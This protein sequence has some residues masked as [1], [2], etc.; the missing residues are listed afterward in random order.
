MKYFLILFL[1]IWLTAQPNDS[2]LF[3]VVITHTVVTNECPD[4]LIIKFK[5]YNRSEKAV[6]TTTLA[7]WIKE[8]NSYQLR[9]FHRCRT[10][11]RHDSTYL[12][13]GI[14]MVGQSEEYLS[15]E[16]FIK[17]N[18]KSYINAEV[19]I[20]LGLFQYMDCAKSIVYFDF[21][22]SNLIIYKNGIKNYDATLNYYEN[23]YRIPE[24]Y[25]VKLTG[26]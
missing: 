19:K 18:K 14:G 15:I 25:E 22:F 12:I 5:I 26:D 24:I 3:P 9:P 17:I 2:A 7:G 6:Y 11:H 21:D 23:I 20:G 1:P 4:T 10:F 8:G 16:N 13:L